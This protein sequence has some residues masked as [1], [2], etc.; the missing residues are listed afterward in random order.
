MCLFTR[1]LLVLALA[2][3]GLLL[4]DSGGLLGLLFRL[5]LLK[6]DLLH[7]ED[8][9][10]DVL[11]HPRLVTLDGASVQKVFQL[12]YRLQVPYIRDVHW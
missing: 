8:T 9:L 12:R 11:V 7:L 3:S 1:Q 5:Q 4:R 10:E 2:A 6:D